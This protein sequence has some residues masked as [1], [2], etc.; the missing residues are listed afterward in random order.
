MDS[1]EIAKRMPVSGRTGGGLKEKRR[2]RG[3]R[4]DEQDKEMLMAQSAFRAWPELCMPVC[5]SINA[6]FSAL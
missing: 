6:S 2:T 3:E 1:A 4:D 5:G